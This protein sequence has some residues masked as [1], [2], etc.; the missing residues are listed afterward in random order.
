MPSVENNQTRPEV[1]LG[2]I[3]PAL[4]RSLRLPRTTFYLLAIIALGSV[5]GIFVPQGQSPEYYV[6]KYGQLG[7]TVVRHLGIDH[8]YS[9]TWYVLLLALLLLSLAACAKRIWRL[10]RDGIAGPKLR[11]LQGRMQADNSLTSEG[12]VTGDVEFAKT[13]LATSLRRRRYRVGT[14]ED[15]DNVHWLVG[16]KWRYA[17]SGLALAHLAVLAIAAGAI[18]GIWPGLAVDKTVELTEGET[19]TDPDGDFEFALKLNDFSMEYYPDQAMVKAY[20]SDLS[21]LEGETEIKRKIV[22]VNQPLSYRHFSFFQSTWGLDG[23]TLE[24]APTNG[25]VETIEFPLAPATGH[26]SQDAHGYEVPSADSVRYTADQT[27]AIVVRG[28]VG[29]A[30]ERD[31]EIIGSQSEFLRNPAVQ[32]RVVSG[33]ATGEH[34]F[35]ELGWLK[36]GQ[37]VAY[38][39][40]T[41]QLV[42]LRY[43]SGIAV[44]RDYGVPLV[45][46]GFVALFVGLSLTFYLRPRAIVAKL[47]ATGTQVSITLSA[48]QDTGAGSERWVQQPS[49]ELQDIIN[50]VNRDAA[51]SGVE[52]ATAREE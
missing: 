17:A 23:F 36:Q 35:A 4:W 44:R 19:Y 18:L 15:K 26:G 9:S 11:A 14:D 12:I 51:A 16:H 24:V 1:G 46:L 2:D 47:A 27:A 45:W 29:D 31:G 22:V 34:D 48:F 42:D 43:Y 6:H 38:D 50:S 7:N 3:L 21:I 39:G 33:F 32:I 37:P 28:F 49:A 41:I 52:P 13:A 20:K 10:A 30:W 40:G 8:L 25:E 5:I